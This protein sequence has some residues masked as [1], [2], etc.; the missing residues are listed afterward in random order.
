MACFEESKMG[1]H[2]HREIA[3][4]LGFCVTAVRRVRQKFGA[5]P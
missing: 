3:E 2:E 4:N 5:F 1:G